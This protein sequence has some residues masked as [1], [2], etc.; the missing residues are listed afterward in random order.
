MSSDMAAFRA[1]LAVF[2]DIAC[3]ASLTP[4]WVCISGSLSSFYYCQR[5]YMKFSLLCMWYWKFLQI[6]SL[7]SPQEVVV[8]NNFYTILHGW[9]RKNRIEI[10]TVCLALRCCRCLVACLAPQRLSAS[11]RK[12]T[13]WLKKTYAV[14]A[15]MLW[16]LLEQED[17]KIYLHNGYFNSRLGVKTTLFR[18]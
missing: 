3:L 12:R 6:G 10:D 14:V 11:R 7:E 9:G 16:C 15:L 17:M 5:S 2:L 13:G 18:S 4:C 8:N 1:V